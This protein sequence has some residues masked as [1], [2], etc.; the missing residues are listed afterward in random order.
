[1]HMSLCTYI[2]IV[3]LWICIR[4]V[5]GLIRKAMSFRKAFNVQFSRLVTETDGYVKISDVIKDIFW[6]T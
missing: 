2:Y 6:T 1:M 5:N 3:Y 4:F